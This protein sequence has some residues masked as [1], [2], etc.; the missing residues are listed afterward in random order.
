MKKKILIVEDE[1]KLLR[2]IADKL[3]REGFDTL[4]AR[5]G[6]EGAKIAINEKPDLILLDI[7]MPVMDGITALNQIRNDEWGKKVPVIM[8]TN[9]SGGVEVAKCLQRGVHDYLVKS[10][11]TLS[12]VVKQIN[13]KLKNN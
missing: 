12:D 6:E 8:L 11:W 7:I 10:D 13:N 1:P 4:E 3:I 5:N 2:A 9:L